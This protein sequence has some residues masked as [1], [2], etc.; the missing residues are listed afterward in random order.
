MSMRIISSLSLFAILV[1]A[2]PAFSL[3]ISTSISSRGT[4]TVSRMEGFDYKTQGGNSL[5]LASLLEWDS[6]TISGALGVHGTEASNLGGG[7][8]YR[9]YEGVHIRVQGEVP[10]SPPSTEETSAPFSIDGTSRAQATTNGTSRVRAGLGGGGGGF[11]SRYRE[12][13]Q[14]LFYP[15][16]YAFLFLDAPTGSPKVRIRYTL[17]FEW[18]FRKDLAASFSLGFSIGVLYTWTNPGEAAK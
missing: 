5:E 3:D 9:G 17:P 2:V 12:T 15:S 13:D 1:S 6:F 16:V 7:W 8:G 14:V 18:Y 11:F 4:V 10:L